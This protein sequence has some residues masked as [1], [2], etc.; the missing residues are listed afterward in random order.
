MVLQLVFLRLIVAVMR[1]LLPKMVP[2]L[3]KTAV[4]NIP[5]ISPK[6]AIGFGI[7][8]FIQGG[9]IEFLMQKFLGMPELPPGQQVTLGPGQVQEVK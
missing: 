5:N 9:G 7:Y 8:Q 1:R 2:E 6:Q 3:M 4:G